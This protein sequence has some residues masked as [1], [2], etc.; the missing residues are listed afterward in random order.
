MRNFVAAL[1]F[2]LLGI[3]GIA[4]EPTRP[5]AIVFTDVRI[6]DGTLPE[7]SGKAH[8]LV[9]G[10]VIERIS[11]TPFASAE[12][13]GA[14][15]VDGGGR[16]LMP[17]LIDAHVH[18]MFEAIPQMV[19]LDADV[20][21]I[22]QVAN[23]AARAT[24]LRGFTT[25]R[26]LGGSSFG[27]KRAIDEG[28]TP[29][30][31]IFPSGAMISQTSGHGDFRHATEVPREA[32]A[33][34]SYSER[35]GMTAIADG[36][37]QVLLRAR[38]QLR[39]GATQLKL[40]AGGGVSSFFDPL[41][42]TQYTAAELRAAVVAAEN[43]GTYVAVHAYTPRAVRMAVEAGVRCVE[44][45]QLIDEPTAKLLAENQVWLCLQPFVEDPVDQQPAN[46]ASRAKKNLVVRGT[47]EA[48]R[49]AKQ[50]GIAVAFGTDTLFSATAA[51]D[52]GRILARLRKWYSPAEALVMATSTNA[53]L[54]A[55]CGERDPYGGRLGV[56]QEGALADLL[57]VDG[58]PL[59]DLDLVADPGRNFVVIVKDGAVVKNAL[60]PSRR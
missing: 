56:V 33:P 46:P 25:V 11:T 47:D 17:G 42:V 59:A 49:L 5:T 27:L 32:G 50:H 58:N 22:N 54:L 4:Q 31:R 35:V 28:I 53:R 41:D 55:M 18:T 38:E 23:A 3:H 60:P 39:Q 20:G 9:R 21:Y 51:K 37:E 40:M 57:L 10:N 30:P 6:F 13:D 36:E 14:T 45:G 2:S 8:V 48:Y 24:L 15:V 26:D 16:T 29:G 34:L 43:W 44:H 12:I 19:A 7:L 1:S 52:Q